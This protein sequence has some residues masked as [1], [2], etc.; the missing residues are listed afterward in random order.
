[1]KFTYLENTHKNRNQDTSIPRITIAYLLMILVV[2]GISIALST[3]TVSSDFAQDYLAACAVRDG[4][5]PNLPLIQLAQIYGVHESV[6][7]S[8]QNAHPP[9][10]ILLAVPFTFYSWEMAHL[11]WEIQLCII[12]G[13]LLIIRPIRLVDFILLSPAWIVGI[14]VGNVDVVVICL[15][16]TAMSSFPRVGMAVI[17][18]LA[19]ALKIYPLLFIAGL[20]AV[21]HYR[22]FFI[23]LISGA[24]LTFFATLCLGLN[25]LIGWLLHIPHNISSY[26]LSVFNISLTKFTAVLRIGNIPVI[27]LGILMIYLQKSQKKIE[28]LLAGMLLVSP[29]SWLHQLTILSN[30]LRMSELIGC[31]VCCV[32]IYS[33]GLFDLPQKGFICASASF[34]LTCLVIII[35]I[36]LFFDN[37]SKIMTNST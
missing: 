1:M 11:L 24:L 37:N 29:L 3:L 19:A 6:V 5:N 25:S 17:L 21:R 15:C 8:A 18:G 30:R 31:S 7:T 2:L 20:C 16:L 32:L 28:P 22:L 34:L 9:L 12:L 35:Y 26:A 33:F 4:I 23:A 10:V 36:R 27:I 13:V 14:C